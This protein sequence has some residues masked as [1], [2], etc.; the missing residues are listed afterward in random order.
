MEKEGS[1]LMPTKAGAAFAL[2]CFYG[3]FQLLD[4]QCLKVRQ[5]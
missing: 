4:S 1:S 5:F 2:P 3:L